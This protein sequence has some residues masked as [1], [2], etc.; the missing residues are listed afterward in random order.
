MEDTSGI[1]DDLSSALALIQRRAGTSQNRYVK[2]ETNK[3]KAIKTKHINQP[4][5][6]SGCC[7]SPVWGLPK[8]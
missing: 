2:D 7:G 8:F 1:A 5:T 3:V 4:V 6:I